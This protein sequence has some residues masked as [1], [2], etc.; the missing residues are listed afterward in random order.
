[1]RCDIDENGDKIFARHFFVQPLEFGFVMMTGDRCAQD[2]EGNGA[3]S[4]DCGIERHRKWERVIVAEIN[5]D[6]GNKR[7][8]KEQIDVC[9]KNDRIDPGHQMNEMMMIDPVDCDDDE[10][11]DIGKKSGPHFCQGIR[12]RIMRSLQLQNHDGNE[13][14]DY[15]IAESFDPVRFHGSE[16]NTEGPARKLAWSEVRGRRLSIRRGPRFQ[17][18][19]LLTVQCSAIAGRRKKKTSTMRTWVKNSRTIR[20]RSFSSMVN[21]CTAHPVHV[22]HNASVRIKKMRANSTPTT[23]ARKKTLRRKIIFACSMFGVSTVFAKSGRMCNANRRNRP[24][25]DFP[26][27]WRFHTPDCR[28]E[29]ARKLR[30]TCKSGAHAHV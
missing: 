23:K 30:L 24:W 9:P 17:G 10:A 21:K 25:Q 8:P 1:D 6:P 22:F 26:Q 7:D 29:K 14:G 2:I 11:Q 16:C 15:A 12:G 27:L 20:P 5:R 19:C 13:N 4:G 28:A 18:R 3:G